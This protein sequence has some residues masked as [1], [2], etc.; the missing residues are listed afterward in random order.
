M[1]NNTGKIKNTIKPNKLMKLLLSLRLTDTVESL[2]TIVE[3]KATLLLSTQRKTKQKLHQRQKE[4]QLKAP[5]L[6]PEP[7][8]K[9]AWHEWYILLKPF[10]CAASLITTPLQ[11][12]HD[13]YLG[14]FLQLK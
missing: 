8:P 2:F 7:I 9:S 3:R 5:P 4:I 12:L 13:Q 1:V 10:H 14:L 6:H 11:A